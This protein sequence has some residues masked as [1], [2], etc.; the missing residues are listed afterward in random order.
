MTAFINF[1]L[2]TSR[3]DKLFYKSFI[4]SPGAYTREHF[5]VAET[6]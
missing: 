6:K 1:L 4:L 3:T 5:L 2:S